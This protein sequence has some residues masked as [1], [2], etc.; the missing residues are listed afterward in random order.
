MQAVLKPGYELRKGW[1]KD[2]SLL[3]KFM[4]LTYQEL[5]PEQEDLSHLNKT[6]EGYFSA[7]T[8][9]WWV[10]N[11]QESEN[12]PTPVACLWMGNGVDQVT[13][14]RYGHIFLLYVIPSHRRQGIAKA[15][16]HQAQQWAQNRGDRQIGLQVFPFAQPALK[17]Y[18][19]LGYQTYSLM[20]LKPLKLEK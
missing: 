3:V 2:R 11:F 7:E 9:L 19:S 18:Q 16:L 5:F 4:Y 15:L 6:I 10:D 17:L 14:D 12:K 20:M 8:P 13:G 1:G